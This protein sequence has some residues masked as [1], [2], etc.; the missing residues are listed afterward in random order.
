METFLDHLADPAFVAKVRA[1]APLCLPHYRQSIEKGTDPDVFESLR[2][3]QVAHWERLVAELGEFI[4]KHD[5]RY[6]HEAVGE[7]GTAWIRAIDAI[8]GTRSF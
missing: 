7:E 8:V 6:R 4:R 5:H 2:Q 3:V 1:A